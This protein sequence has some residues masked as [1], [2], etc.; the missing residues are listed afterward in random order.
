[1]KIGALKSHKH[2]IMKLNL[3]RFISFIHLFNDEIS[4]CIYGIILLFNDESLQCIYG[5][6]LLFKPLKGLF[7]KGD[8]AKAISR[9]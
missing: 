3:L 1:M 7:P 8:G 2:T 9:D 4:Q 6:I 5:I